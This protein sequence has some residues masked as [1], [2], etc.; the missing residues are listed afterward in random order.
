MTW[1]APQ[2]DNVAPSASTGPHVSSRALYAIAFSI[3]NQKPIEFLLLPSFHFSI[4][5]FPLSF[6]F[7]SVLLSSPFRLPLLLHFF[8][9]FLR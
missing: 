6:R 4:K 1:R 8:A 2:R 9:T 5:I 3:N 7:F